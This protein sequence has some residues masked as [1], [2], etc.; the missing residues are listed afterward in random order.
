MT[1]SSASSPTEHDAA[2][3]VARWGGGTAVSVERF[4]TGLANYVYD[5]ALADGGRVVARLQRPGAGAA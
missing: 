5:V 1:L 3:I 4:P 2:A